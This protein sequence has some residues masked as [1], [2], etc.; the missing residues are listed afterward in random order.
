MCFFWGGILGALGAGICY[1]YT[2][3][4][5]RDTANIGALILRIVFSDSYNLYNYTQETQNS[6]DN[7]LSPHVAA[8]DSVIGTLPGGRSLMKSLLWALKGPP[9]RPP[10]FPKPLRGSL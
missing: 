7:Y 5:L 2:A 10:F 6:I 1:K 8:N 4:P 3:G 9:R